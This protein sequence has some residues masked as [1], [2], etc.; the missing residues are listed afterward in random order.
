M[1]KHCIFPDFGIFFLRDALTDLAEI[2][3]TDTRDDL[4]W[5]TIFIFAL[6]PL[7]PELQA[8]E[9]PIFAFSR[10]A[11]FT[12]FENFF[13]RDDL[14]DFAEI[15]HGKTRDDLLSG[16]IFTFAPA[17]LSPEIQ[18]RENP[19][20]ERLVQTNI[21]KLQSAIFLTSEQELN[22]RKIA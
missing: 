3:W 10:T 4:L 16:P 22:R 13:L 12:D 11:F 6:V 5:G 2:L 15:V 14:T 17:L 7:S 20:F 9:N 18:A 19:I 21:G 1:D 8:P